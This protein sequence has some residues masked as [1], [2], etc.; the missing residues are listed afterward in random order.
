M[1]SWLRMTKLILE[2]NR[3]RGGEF[4]KPNVV[5]A[6]ERGGLDLRWAARAMSVSLLAYAKNRRSDVECA[7]GAA[8]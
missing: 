8:R 5:V 6:G 2:Y 7:G 1:P 3:R 4:N